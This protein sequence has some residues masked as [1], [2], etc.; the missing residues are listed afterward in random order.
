MKVS[1]IE[2]YFRGWFVGNFKPSCFE[3]TEFEVGLLTHKKGEIWPA[4]IHKISTEI[5]LLI[6]GEMILQNKKLISGDV[7]V[8]EPNEVADPIFLSDCKLIVIKTPSIPTDKYE[9]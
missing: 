5:N 2:D 3:T 1:K 8:I 7:F 6:E 4:H 9:I